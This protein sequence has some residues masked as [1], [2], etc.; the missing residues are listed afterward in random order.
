MQL[1][2][3]QIVATAGI[4]LLACS[5]AG[6]PARAQTGAKPQGTTV[7]YTMDII[8]TVESVDQK[9]REVV[10]RGP[11]GGKLAVFAGPEVENLAKVKAGDKVNVHYIEALAASLAKPG[12]GAGGGNVST[13]AGIS[14]GTTAAGAP[15]GTVGGQVKANVLVQAVNKEANTITFVGQDNIARTIAVQDADARKFLQTLK[16][17][18]RLDLVYTESLALSLDPQS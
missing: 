12:S 13:Q 14:R 18:D 7:A 3:A 2:V 17:G 9:T 5:V 10:L 15:T 11:D 6:L 1:K 8:A 4:G 16:A